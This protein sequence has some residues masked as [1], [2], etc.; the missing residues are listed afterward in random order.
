MKSFTDVREPSVLR[1]GEV[2]WSRHT[3]AWYDT[4]RRRR[5]GTQAEFHICSTKS[6]LVNYRKYCHIQGRVIRGLMWNAWFTWFTMYRNIQVCELTQ[7][8]HLVYSF[9]CAST[10]MR[11]PYRGRLGL[12]R[13]PSQ[14]S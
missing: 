5:V 6:L 3:L 14:K 13:R 8:R 2:G 10:L 1:D 7:L 4:T 12:G 9:P 11:K